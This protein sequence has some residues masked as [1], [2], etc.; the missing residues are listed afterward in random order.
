MLSYTEFCLKLFTILKEEKI[1]SL[2]MQQLINDALDILE[3]KQS[4][5]DTYVFL[6][7]LLNKRKKLLVSN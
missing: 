5:I 4:P 6:E 3:F 2:R 7:N 1:E